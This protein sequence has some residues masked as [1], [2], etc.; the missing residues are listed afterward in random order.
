MTL[1]G[2]ETV[3]PVPAWDASLLEERSMF[4]PTFLNFKGHQLS[5]SSGI[6]PLA[7]GRFLVVAGEPSVLVVSDDGDEKKDRQAR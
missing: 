7:D 4:P 3:M 1:P 2:G 6:T 5:E